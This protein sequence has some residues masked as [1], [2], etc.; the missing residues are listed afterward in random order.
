MGEQD[1]SPVVIVEDKTEG[2]TLHL[3]AFTTVKVRNEATLGDLLVSTLLMVLIAMFL[4][5]WIYGAIMGRDK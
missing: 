3:D 2:T 5:K 1:T 4:T